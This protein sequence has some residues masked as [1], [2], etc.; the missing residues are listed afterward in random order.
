MKRVLVLILSLVLC[1]G[2]AY[3]EEM[4]EPAV[5]ENEVSFESQDVLLFDDVYMALPT[6]FVPL[7]Q[8][9]ENSV[10]AYQNEACGITVYKQPVYI[11]EFYALIVADQSG[12]IADLKILEINGWF[13]I[14]AT[15][16]DATM[17][18]TYTYIDDDVT[19]QMVFNA[20]NAEQVPA[21]DPL[22]V[23]GSVYFADAE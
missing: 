15:S 16:A 20:P 3:A 19:L 10:A 12:A 1:V 22:E 2:F 21:F 11:D 6:D 9:P 7:E 23:L 4:P 13:T 17:L 5:I 18:Y 14:V 8:L